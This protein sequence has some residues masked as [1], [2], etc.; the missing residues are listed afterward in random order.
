MA[1]KD[2]INAERAHIAFF[3]L[4]NAGKSS[5]V[6]ALTNQSV[7][8]V[9]D[10]A[11][12]TT[13]PVRKAMELL[14]AGPVLIVDTPGIDDEGELGKLRIDKARQVMD[15]TN[16]AVLVIDGATGASEMD[17]ELAA[18]LSARSIPCIVALNKS[19]LTRNATC[20]AASYRLTAHDIAIRQGASAAI[21]G[22]QDVVSAD[23]GQREGV[24]DTSKKPSLAAH[25][26][27]AVS[28]LTGEGIHELKEEIAKQAAK[29]ASKAKRRI[30]AD[31][32]KP[33]DNVVLVTPIDASAP[34]GRLILPQQMTIRDV[35]DA[36]A[37][38]HVTRET[39]LSSMMDSLAHPPRMVITDSQAFKMVA[40]LIPRS[41]PLTSFSILMARYKGTLDSQ[42]AGANELDRLHDGSKVLL[43]EGCTHHRQCDDIGTVKIPKWIRAY[44]N[45][46]VDFEFT[47]G[48]DFPEG[49]SRYQMVI[50]C[51]GCMLNEREM[52]SR[53]RR[54]NEQAI[55]CTNYGMAIAKT[56]GILERALEPLR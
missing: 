32:L 42:V 22:K 23:G 41:I 47:S 39:E 51:G 5:L 43:A 1:L 17:L 50:H 9:S 6:N 3:G 13:D 48:A 19:D 55:P 53:M 8:V 35:L 45:C 10:I 16:L 14:P 37:L 30:V 24:A 25:S 34:K 44:A 20:R 27:I 21:A 46:E 29:T 15:S 26:I 52:G 38:A 49:L 56:N 4:R 36:G 33:G 31:L 2:A 18:E 28:A 40:N 12:T 7:S 11:G 54:A